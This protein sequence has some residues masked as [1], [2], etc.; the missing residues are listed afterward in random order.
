L[1]FANRPEGASAANSA[2]VATRLI[3]SFIAVRY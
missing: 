1:S 2:A 3:S